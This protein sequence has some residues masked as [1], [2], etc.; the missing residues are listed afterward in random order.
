[1]DEKKTTHWI[2]LVLEYWQQPMSS[3]NLKMNDVLLL[4]FQGEKAREIYLKS[5]EE[6]MYP[7]ATYLCK[8]YR[9]ALF[10][11]K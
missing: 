8:V 4:Q 9:C 10:K 2:R 7:T 5:F 1:M 3:R 6:Y 11:A